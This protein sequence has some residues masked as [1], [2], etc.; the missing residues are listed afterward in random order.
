[1]IY[2]HVVKVPAIVLATLLPALAAAEPAIQP[3]GL[4]AAADYRELARYPEWSAALEAGSVDPVLDSRAPTRQSRLG[5]NGAGP[6]LTVWA[7]TISARAGEAVTLFA[8]L[9]TVNARPTLV[10]AL[11]AAGNA[12]TGAAV[13]GELTGLALGTLGTVAYRDDG[14]APDTV[15]GDG[16]YTA[17]YTLP[18]APRPALGQA[19]SVMV[20]VTAL[21]DGGEMRRA[22]GGFQFSNPA[23]RLTGRYVDSVRDGNLV[24]AAEVEALAPGRVHLA[25]TLADLRDQPFATAQAARTLAAGKQWVALTFY[26][27]AFHDRGVTGAARLASLALA[28][29]DTMPNALGAIVVDA[30]R[31]RPY[32]LAQF[33]RLPFNN[34]ALLEQAR[35][36][37]LDAVP[38]LR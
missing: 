29:T 5:P 26:G 22:A 13:S 30:H 31:T 25:G 16:V 21:L 32:A 33:T 8:T 10:E 23:A 28:S 24:I 6:R 38:A 12:V 1:M 7:S 18:A 20:T 35:R 14:V 34:P 2:K 9:T 36:L 11:P 3:L 4:Q 27:L 15:A 17:R 19:D 37:Q